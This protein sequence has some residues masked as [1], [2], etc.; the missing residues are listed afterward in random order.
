MKLEQTLVEE[1]K[2]QQEKKVVKVIVNSIEIKPNHKL[3]E[4]HLDEN[5]DFNVFQTEWKQP[6]ELVFI[7]VNGKFVEKKEERK[8]V[9]IDIFNPNFKAQKQSHEIELKNGVGYV[10]A[11][12]YENAV[13]KFKTSNPQYFNKNSTVSV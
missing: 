6:K 3:F 9:M 13:K 5:G 2:A 11:L 1:R 7:N 10:T 12:N 8:P 4:F